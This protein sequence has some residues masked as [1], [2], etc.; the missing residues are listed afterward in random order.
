MLLLQLL[1]LC[2]SQKE[3]N[4]HYRFVCLLLIMQI[5]INEHF[6]FLLSTLVGT[7]FPCGKR[8]PNINCL[9]LFFFLL[10]ISMNTSRK[11]I[12]FNTNVFRTSGYI[13]FLCL[14]VHCGLKVETYFFVSIYMYTS[15]QKISNIILCQQE[16]GT[17]AQ[18]FF[19]VVDQLK[20]RNILFC[21]DLNVHQWVENFKYHSMPVGT[22][23]QW[24]E[25]FF[26]VVDQLF[27][28]RCVKSQKVPL[29]YYL[30]PPSSA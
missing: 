24:V 11:K 22:R 28:C 10:C 26:L 18:N 20:N 25:F 15:G 30:R 27:N 1:Q 13:F 14:K 3:R 16:L 17:S 29:N 2:N 23:H 9:K 4:L 21:L 12:S 5:G 7:I 6:H 19:L 8:W